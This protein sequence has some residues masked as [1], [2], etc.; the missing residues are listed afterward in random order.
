MKDSGEGSR[1][2]LVSSHIESETRLNAL[3]F[4]HTLEDISDLS[5][6]SDS[7]RLTSIELRIVPIELGQ[8]LKLFGELL[9][10]SFR[11]C[12]SQFDGTRNVHTRVRLKEL[13]TSSQVQDSSARLKVEKGSSEGR[14][15]AHAE[16]SRE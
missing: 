8:R 1:S 10:R 13:D 3:A 14:I 7:N 4:H 11:T 5:R 12:D 2:S 15:S 16:K 9:Q 6:G